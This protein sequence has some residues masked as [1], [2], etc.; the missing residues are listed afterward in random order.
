VHFPGRSRRKLQR[1]EAEQYPPGTY[2]WAAWSG[3]ARLDP[4]SKGDWTGRLGDWASLAAIFTGSGYFHRV[5]MQGGRVAATRKWQ[6][7]VWRKAEPE[8]HVEAHV[9]AQL[10]TCTW[11]KK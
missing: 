10:P 3:I 11:A 4:A 5:W 8:P 2:L 1:Q 7:V 6:A 9:E